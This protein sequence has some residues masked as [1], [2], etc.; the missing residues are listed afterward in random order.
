MKLIKSLLV[1]PAALGLLSP[2]SV[3][4]SELNLNEIK[5]IEPRVNDNVLDVFI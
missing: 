2:L 1:A 3:S 4:A 5:K